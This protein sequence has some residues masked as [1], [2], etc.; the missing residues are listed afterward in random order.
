[1]G[2]KRGTTPIFECVRNDDEI[3]FGRVRVLL[4]FEDIAVRLCGVLL[5][6]RM[7]T[8]F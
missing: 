3:P 4:L 6:K 2:G 5:S 1:M 7:T 8:T